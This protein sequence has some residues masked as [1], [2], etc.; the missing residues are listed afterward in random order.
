MNKNS[1]KMRE[2]ALEIVE[3]NENFVKGGVKC[4]H[5]SSKY[6]KV[7]KYLIFERDLGY[8][9]VGKI[10]NMTP[11]AVNNIVNRMEEK[12]FNCFYIRKLCKN[13]NIDEKYFLN[14]SDLVGEIL[15]ERESRTILQ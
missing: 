10:L 12:S 13:L 15:D 6:G 8:K 2:I 3:F 7:L 11:Q 5:K 1:K 9:D 4:S 14:L